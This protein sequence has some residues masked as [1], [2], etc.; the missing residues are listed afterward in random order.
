MADIILT[1]TLKE[2]EL[3]SIK[4]GL[5]E[6]YPNETT[7]SDTPLP[8][9]VWLLTLPVKILSELVRDG[10]KRKLT[11]EAASVAQAAVTTSIQVTLPDGTV[12]NG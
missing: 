1:L 2:E 4:T 12:I 9:D 11:R 6:L 3:P 7:G 8:D 10:L 5:L